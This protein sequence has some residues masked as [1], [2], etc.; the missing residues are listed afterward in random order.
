MSD[1]DELWA[2]TVGT[3]DLA[4]IEKVRD[5]DAIAVVLRI[6]FFYERVVE[7]CLRRLL[8]AYDR[9]RIDKFRFSE[10]VSLLEAFGLE[11]Q[12]TNFLKSV[13]AIRNKAAHEDGYVLDDDRVRDFINGNA[14]FVQRAEARKQIREGSTKEHMRPGVG[15]DALLI[16][17]AVS[18]TTL[19]ED[20]VSLLSTH[21]R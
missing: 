6:S 4:A 14:D 18:T 15:A 5:L 21:G 7:V 20:C 17:L 9:A 3:F 10:K 2:A 19:V 13:Y 12:A 8:P 11:Q 1:F 16:V